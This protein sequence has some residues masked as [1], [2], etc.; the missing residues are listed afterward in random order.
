M[1]LS[2]HQSSVET[3]HAEFM[4][5]MEESMQSMD[6][7]QETAGMGNMGASSSNQLVHMVIRVQRAYRLASYV[8]R[9]FGPTLFVDSTGHPS[10]G[11]VTSLEEEWARRTCELTRPPRRANW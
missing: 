1:E 10:Y 11:K 6:Q 5:D 3:G 4:S 2:K 7:S 8:Y 9:H